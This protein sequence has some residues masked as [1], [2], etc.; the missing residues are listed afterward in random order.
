MSRS[1]MQESPRADTRPA[2]EAA[3][4][5]RAAYNHCEAVARHHY[6]N[7]PVASLLLPRALRPHVAAVYAFARQADDFADEASYEGRRLELLASCRVRLDRA[8]MGQADDEVHL[9]L[10]DTLAR[11]RLPVSL[12]HDLLSAFEQDV[13][14]SSYETFDDVLAYCRL[15]A[16]PVGRLVLHLA[17]RAEPALLERSDAICTALQLTNFW[18]DVAI[19]LDKGRCYL[20]REDMRRFGC[21]PGDLARRAVSEPFAR[22]LGFQIDRTRGLFDRGRDLPALVGGRLGF[23]LR[24]VVLGG[25]RVLDRIEEAECDVFSRRPKLTRADWGRLMARA[26]MGGGL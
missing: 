15:S 7:F 5:L 18:Q 26:V 8:S 3:A 10:A 16:N 13:R 12:L 23:E 21:A 20:P 19:D 9:A 11:H 1:T 22:L 17:G 4:R 2:P 24:L 14:V 6:E 25:R